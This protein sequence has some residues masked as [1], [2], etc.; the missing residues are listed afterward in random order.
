MKGAFL[1]LLLASAAS[2]QTAPQPGFFVNMQN[3]WFDS[4]YATDFE[5]A[6]RFM[7][8]YDDIV[9]A[10]MRY[11]SFDHASQY[12]VSNNGGSIRRLD[13]DVIDLE[14]TTRVGDILLS[15]GARIA[16]I[17]YN[18][19]LF[20]PGQTIDEHEKTDLGGVTIAG[21]GR[22]NLVSVVAAVYGGRL[23]ILQ[24]DWSGDRTNGTNDDLNLQNETFVVPEAFAGLEARFTQF[25]TRFT[26]EL[27]EWNGRARAGDFNQSPGGHDFG[28]TGYGF[29]LGWVF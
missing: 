9:G 3:L 29:D 21:E 14:A 4:E 25:F 11:W 7:L 10:R 24:G 16:H 1:A 12:S 26:V 19:H 22:T 8:G 23:S 17:D 15:G 5:Y 20:D 2:A 6:P 18:R 27:Q 13:F 28:F